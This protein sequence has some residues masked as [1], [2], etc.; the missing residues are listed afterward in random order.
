M[1]R[2]SGGGSQGGVGEK[3]EDMEGIVSV[4]ETVRVCDAMEC[5]GPV[6]RSEYTY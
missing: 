3:M 5:N 4:G 6:V 2:W 1:M